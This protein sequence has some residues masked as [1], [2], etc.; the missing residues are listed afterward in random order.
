MFGPARGLSSQP[1]LAR[2]LGIR[3][4]SQLWPVQRML[5]LDNRAG[6]SLR[7]LPRFQEFLTRL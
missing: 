2:P 4:P 6:P 1:L 7:P 3:V 5:A